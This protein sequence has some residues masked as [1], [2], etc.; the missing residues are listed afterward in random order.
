MGNRISYRWM[1]ICKLGVNW[2]VSTLTI[3]LSPTG[4]KSSRSFTTILRQRPMS[5][6]WNI[7]C[8]PTIKILK[9]FC[10]VIEHT[11]KLLTQFCVRVNPG[12][13]GAHTAKPNHN[14]NYCSAL[15]LLHRF[16]FAWVAV[17]MHFAAHQCTMYMEYHNCK[18]IF[19]SRYY[20]NLNIELC[21]IYTAAVAMVPTRIYSI[22]V[23]PV[24]VCMYKGV[25]SFLR[26]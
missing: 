6:Y 11:T 14:T 17:Q 16:F 12:R 23:G 21:R 4:Q 20:V 18:P 13:N 1:I 2:W 7:H 5:H 9:F 15:H 25:P 3:S 22:Q 26:L 10:D 19:Y 8:V 24:V